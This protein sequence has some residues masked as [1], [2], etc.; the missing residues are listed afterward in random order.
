MAS[1]KELRAKWRSEGRCPQCGVQV[2]KEDGT[3]TCRPCLE[4][5][6]EASRRYRSRKREDRA[7]K[8]AIQGSGK[9]EYPHKVHL[10][11]YVHFVRA[12]NPTMGH[13]RWG[14]LKSYWF[15]LLVQSRGRDF[16]AHRALAV[17]AAVERGLSI[18][19]AVR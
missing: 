18:S 7:L 4:R 17:M 9:L 3:V 13:I 15:K 12:T 2:P 19:D 14:R 11:P 6:A 8:K 16:G 10:P 1:T 5:M